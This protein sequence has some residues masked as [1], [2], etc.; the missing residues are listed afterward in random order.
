MCTNRQALMLTSLTI[1]MHMQIDATLEENKAL[2]SK[3]GV[4][5]FPTLKVPGLSAL[6]PSV[7]GCQQVRARAKQSA[8]AGGLL[9]LPVTIKLAKR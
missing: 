9:F 5:G 8:L 7:P 4:Q 1:V 2:S 6:R 3:Y